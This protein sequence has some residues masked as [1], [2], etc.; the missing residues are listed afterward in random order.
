[1]K[2]LLFDRLKQDLAAE[3]R[4]A[5][6]AQ[7]PDLTLSIEEIYHLLVLPP[8]K[9]MGHLAFGVFPLAKSL[10]QA[11]PVI[12]QKISEL[13]NQCKNESRLLLHF[14]S[15]QNIGPYVNFFFS[16]KVLY[17]TILVPYLTGS[18]FKQKLFELAPRTMIEY[19]QPNTHKE[20][21]V[22]HMRNACL[23]DAIV[24]L[25]R[26]SGVSVISTTF[27]GDVGTHVAKCLWYLKYH[28]QEPLPETGRGEWLGKMYS[29]GH[30][31]LEDREDTPDEIDDREKL[32]IILKQIESRSGEFYDLWRETRQWSIDLMNE[33]YEWCG[34]K[35]DHWYWESDVDSD[36]VKTIK[37]YF[38]EGKLIESEGAIGMD[39]STENLGFCVLLKSDGNGLYS[40]KDIELARRKFV[41]HS[42]ERSVYV[43]DMRQ[44]LH[45]KQV[46]AS[47][48]RLGFKEADQCFHLQYNFV[49]LPD[50]AM[51]SRKGN[52]VPLTQ[53]VSQMEAHVKENYLDRYGS[54]WTQD[55]V[56]TTARIIA[57]G[58]IKY[59][60][61]K[62]DPNKKIV[63]DMAEWLKLDG[64]SG[65][66]IQYAYARIQ[67]ILRK[68]PL[69]EIKNNLQ[70]ALNQTTCSIAETSGNESK[71][72]TQISLNFPDH[73]NNN[74]ENAGISSGT[75]EK[76]S[77]EF[78]KGTQTNISEN[79]TGQYLKHDLELQLMVLLGQL[80]TQVAQAVETYRP[81]V[82]CNYLYEVAKLF[83]QFYHECPIGRAES[84]DLKQDRLTLADATGRVLK[85][86]LSLL[87]IPVPDKM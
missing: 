85:V 40:T 86:G 67:S 11:P 71:K 82:L 87:G 49:E 38:A 41:E 43:V 17:D 6:L 62:M 37:K 5:L 83:S 8:Q 65:P 33:V 68:H 20:L 56:K 4:Q 25:N 60:M 9:E 42:I 1:M 61:L 47:L 84:E 2:K 24:R 77:S 54:E 14:E 73:L 27:P 29:K 39:L 15:A 16:G 66:Y 76:I 48:K 45:F 30:L 3:L 21:H 10:R 35:F 12:A 79:S 72:H 52:I 80:N 46:F 53:L 22:G 81:N 26:Y 32:S 50:G 51:S 69:K 55:E 75:R 58:A 59:G 70:Q 78:G 57:Q 18:G 13:I 36:S 23:G 63:F 7:W 19:S 44:A 28:N 31:F 34:I 64:D 74:L